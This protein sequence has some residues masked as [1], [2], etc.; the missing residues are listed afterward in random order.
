MWRLCQHGLTQQF[1]SVVGNIYSFVSDFEL[2]YRVLHIPQRLSAICLVRVTRAPMGT[3]ATL[4]ASLK[5]TSAFHSMATSNIDG[6][7]I[8][9]AQTLQ[10]WPPEMSSYLWPTSHTDTETRLHFPPHWS[11]LVHG[12]DKTADGKTSSA[13]PICNSG[14]LSCCR[15]VIDSGLSLDVRV[16]RC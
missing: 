2:F 5:G 7:F 3:K 4:T 12:L 14:T 6:F 11:M 13:Q 9:M 16:K 1:K 10:Q 8:L 15:L